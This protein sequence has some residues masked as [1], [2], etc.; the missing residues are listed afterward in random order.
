MVALLT[1]NIYSQR[2]VSCI[3]YRLRVLPVLRHVV[4]VVKFKSKGLIDILEMV[5]VCRATVHT[6]VVSV[7]EVFM[8]WHLLSLAV[9]LDAEKR[10]VV[11]M[12]VS[13]TAAGALSFEEM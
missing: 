11:V 12:V 10:V 8:A 7:C 4:H 5:L 9:V 13:N 1:L 6:V 3:S 2:S